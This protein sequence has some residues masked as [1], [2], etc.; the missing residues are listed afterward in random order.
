MP[1]YKSAHDYISRI[2]DTLVAIPL[3]ITIGNETYE[4]ACY[5]VKRNLPY[6]GKEPVGIK[7]FIYVVGLL[8]TT[9][10]KGHCCYTVEGDTREWYLAGGY[11]D[12]RNRANFR[13]VIKP[14]R[15]APFGNA[16]Q[17]SPYD[18]NLIG[19]KIDVGWSNPFKR[20]KMSVS[21]LGSEDYKKALIAVSLLQAP[22]VDVTTTDLKSKRRKQIKL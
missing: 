12:N 1:K 6:N 2:A 18:V 15:H 14:T 9:E 16:F 3:K 19:S 11:Y 4:N 10:V 17:L 22:V 21:S 13:D 20:F 8:P 7:E 5:Y